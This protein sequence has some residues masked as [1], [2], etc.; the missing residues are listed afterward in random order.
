MIQGPILIPISLK[1]TRSNSRT[2]RFAMN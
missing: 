1:L 2:N